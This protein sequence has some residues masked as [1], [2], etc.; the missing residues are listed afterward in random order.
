MPR[1]PS[2]RPAWPFGAPGSHR[3]SDNPL[4]LVEVASLD[5]LPDDVGADVRAIVEALKLG[6]KPDDLA[7]AVDPRLARPRG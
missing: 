6:L 1:R 2:I 5:V 7:A 4:R 3:Q